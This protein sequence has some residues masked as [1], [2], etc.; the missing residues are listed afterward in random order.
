MLLIDEFL[1]K[2]RGTVMKL[3]GVKHAGPG[4]IELREKITMSKTGLHS[5]ERAAREAEKVLFSESTMKMLSDRLTRVEE[6]FEEVK[7][8][9]DEGS[10]ERVYNRAT[11]HGGTWVIFH[12]SLSY[13]LPPE[14]SPCRIEALFCYTPAQYLATGKDGVQLYLV[15]TNRVVYDMIEC[16]TLG[17]AWSYNPLFHYLFSRCRTCQLFPDRLSICETCFQMLVFWSEVWAISAIIAGQYLAHL[18]YEEKV[19]TGMRREKRAHSNKERRI[20]TRYTYKLIDANEIILHVP[21]GPE[22]P[23]ITGK[24]MGSWMAHTEVEHVPI[25]TRPFERTY[26][27]DRYKASGLQGTTIRFKNGIK[28]NQPIKA[29]NLPHYLDRITQVKA[30]DYES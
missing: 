20:P 24:A 2:I 6:T 28:R 27:A 12:E 8:S 26:R 18:R 23:P 7:T 11:T 10:L 29:E 30:S 17:D 5:L 13:P 9:L 25:T 14:R 4:L 15:D 1:Q 16:E 22:E 19:V 3:D 21:P